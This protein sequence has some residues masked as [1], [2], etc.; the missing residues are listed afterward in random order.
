MGKCKSCNNWWKNTKKNEVALDL[1]F[2][3]PR[4]GQ[5][6]RN[7]SSSFQPKIAVAFNSFSFCNFCIRLMKKKWEKLKLPRIW[8]LTRLFLKLQF[9]LESAIQASNT[10]LITGAKWSQNAG[11]VQKK[12]G[13]VFPLPGFF[14][15]ICPQCTD[16]PPKMTKTFL[17]Q[18][19]RIERQTWLNLQLK[20]ADW[21][22]WVPHVLALPCL[23]MLALYT[24]HQKPFYRSTIKEAEKKKI[25]LQSLKD[26]T[27]TRYLWTWLWFTM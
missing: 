6:A 19:E 20:F 16:A 13:G 9:M 25:N 10:Q 23:D 11:I 17:A 15:R 2:P 3:P 26:G 18:L 24:L 27:A 22:L 21:T 4:Q 5:A 7:C 14:W 1:D 12:G 8:P